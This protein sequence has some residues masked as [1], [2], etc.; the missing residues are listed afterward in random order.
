MHVAVAGISLV[1]VASP[2]REVDYYLLY[3]LKWDEAAAVTGVVPMTKLRLLAPHPAT[4]IPRQLD[5]DL[6][7][8]E[9][10]PVRRVQHQSV[11][12]IP[13]QCCCWCCF[14]FLSSGCGEI[15]VFFTF[16]L[17]KGF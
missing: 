6:V 1:V 11:K 9:P 2:I 7:E 14:L 12:L 8:S 10:R 17:N 3:I 13:N 15:F 16:V 4:A 5:H